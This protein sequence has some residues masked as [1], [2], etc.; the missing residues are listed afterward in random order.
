MAQRFSKTER[1]LVSIRWPVIVSVM[2]GT[3]SLEAVMPPR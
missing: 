2:A 3:P 1:Q